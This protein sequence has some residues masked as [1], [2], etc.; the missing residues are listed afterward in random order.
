MCAFPMQPSAASNAVFASD[1]KIV[2]E[3][4][5]Q[6]FSVIRVAVIEERALGDLLPPLF[7]TIGLLTLC[8][9]T[10]GLKSLGFG[11]GYAT[12]G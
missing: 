2:S 10:K 12:F 11:I 9:S 3:I 7:L 4:S 1:K 8:G 5:D 6:A